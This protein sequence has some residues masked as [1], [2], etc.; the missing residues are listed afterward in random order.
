MRPDKAQKN[1]KSA[2]YLRLIS[3]Q[4]LPP[5]RSNPG[6]TRANQGKPDLKAAPPPQEPCRRRR[7]ESH[8]SSRNESSPPAPSSYISENNKRVSPDFAGRVGASPGFGRTA[9]LR[10]RLHVETTGAA[11]GANKAFIPSGSFKR[12]RIPRSCACEG[13]HIAGWKCIRQ[14]VKGWKL[15]LRSDKT[16][17][18]LARRFNPILRGWVQY[19]GHYYRPML[20]PLFRP[21]DRILIRWACRKYKKLR[22]HHRRAAHWLRRISVREPR[23]WAHW[24][25]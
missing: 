10:P 14:E 17:T 5:N 3:S 18:D 21:L 20:H 15:H 7:E 16:L 12:A 22:G 23:L 9:G 11:L 1:K 2:H 13:V 6:Q 24:E 25:V 8:S 4:G 19:Y